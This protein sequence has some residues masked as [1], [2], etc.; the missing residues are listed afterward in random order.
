MK[1]AITFPNHWAIKNI[2]HSGVAARLQAQAEI[3][4]IAD[5]SRIPHLEGLVRELGLRPIEWHG[6]QPQ[7]ESSNLT[8]V[9]KLQKS[10]VF[11]SQ[12]VATERI[13]QK[14]GQ[15]SRAERIVGSILRFVASTPFSPQLANSVS[16]KRWD[17]TAVGALPKADLLF[18]TN[19][20]DFR[21]DPLIKAAK[22]VDMPV[23]T[24]IPSWD[25]LSTKGVLFTD[26]DEVYVWNEVMQAEV[27]SLLSSLSV[28]QVPI[29]GIPRF[30]VYEGAQGIGPGPKQILFANTA[31]KSCPDQPAVARHLAEALNE[32]AFGDAQ[33]T[34]R[35]HPHDQPADYAFL[36]NY[37]NVYVWPEL[38]ES[39]GVE[40]VPPADDLTV[41]RRMMQ[42]ADVCVNCASTIVLDAAANDVP[43]VSVAY[44]GD[45]EL[46]ENISVRKF[47]QFTHQQPY[48]E[49]GA[50]QMAYGRAE[51]IEA[52]RFALGHP[53]D[54]RSERA[55]LA[56]L[57][58]QGQPEIRLAE[59]LLNCA[60]AIRSAA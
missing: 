47:Y 55:A 40:T 11:E 16:K 2:L 15:R 57:A 27:L 19:P 12:G 23:A 38:A 51:L 29:V 10:L 1:I 53:E 60:G 9:R 43:I 5:P 35:C 54:R 4:G 48:V 3:I 59:A 34:I 56:R 26:F 58:T 32:G 31:T 52:I 36:R 50:G 22:L 6:Y 45:R 42:S 13:L 49:S 33:L 30:G 24:M 7:P 37:A 25:N 41:L 44:D 18:T 46:P 20:V 21:E 14:K 28:S 17:L 39:Y 8:R